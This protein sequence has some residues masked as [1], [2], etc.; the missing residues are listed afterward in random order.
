MR[1]IGIV[2]VVIGAITLGVQGLD[3]LAAD[4]PAG[5][6]RAVETGQMN[7]VAPVMGGIAVTG[8]LLLLAT[9]GRQE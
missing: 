3:T 2:L 6:G 5:D 8:G 7:W 4:R 9:D 1:L